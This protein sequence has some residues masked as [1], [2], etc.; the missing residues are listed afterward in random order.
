MFILGYCLINVI[1]ALLAVL[2]A[3]PLWRFFHLDP[4]LTLSNNHST[5]DRIRCGHIQSKRARRCYTVL[6]RFQQALGTLNICGGPP[7]TFRLVYLLV[8]LGDN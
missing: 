3:R 8:S 5:C 4:L 7:N 1:C 6:A 2:R